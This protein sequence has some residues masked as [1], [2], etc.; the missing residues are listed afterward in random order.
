M[1]ARALRDFRFLA[2]FLTSSLLAAA[3]FYQR[4]CGN[5]MTAMR[6]QRP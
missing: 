1:D 5:A 4:F 3:V 6:R 2:V